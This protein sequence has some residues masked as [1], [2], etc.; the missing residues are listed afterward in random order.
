M[1]L[2]FGDVCQVQKHDIKQSSP[3]KK[4]FLYGQKR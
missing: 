4:G 3:Q 1:A 2:F